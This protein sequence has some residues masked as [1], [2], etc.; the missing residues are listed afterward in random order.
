VQSTTPWQ[1]LHDQGVV[2]AYAYAS[3]HRAR[4][5]YQW[6]V[7]VSAYVAAT[8]RR[9]GHA[10]RLYT[11]LFDLL[12]LQGFAMAFAGITL[13]ND[14]SVGLHESLGFEPV[15]VYPSVGF[16]H[17]SWHDVG[18]WSRPLRRLPASPQPP[19]RLDEVRRDPRFDS[20]LAG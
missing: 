5:A 18:W 16:K 14:A 2:E 19:R 3:P 1:V 8:A 13:P 20:L 7:E 9:R 6:S 10:R 15:G 4:E 12:A 11:V 17:G